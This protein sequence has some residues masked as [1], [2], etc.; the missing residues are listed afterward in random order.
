MFERK[1][2]LWVLSKKVKGQVGIPQCL[3]YDKTRKG[4]PLCSWTPLTSLPYA[5]ASCLTT[6]EETSEET[7]WKTAARLETTQ[8]K[9]GTELPMRGNVKERDDEPLQIPA[10]GCLQ[11]HKWRPYILWPISSAKIF[12]SEKDCDGFFDVDARALENAIC[13]FAT[14]KHV[15]YRLQ[16]C[17]HPR[18]TKPLHRNQTRKLSVYT[19]HNIRGIWFLFQCQRRQREQRFR[20]ISENGSDDGQTWAFHRNAETSMN[21]VALRCGKL[22]VRKARIKYQPRLTWTQMSGVPFYC[23]PSDSCIRG[24]WCH[25]PIVS[26]FQVKWRNF[27][28]CFPAMRQ[29]GLSSNAKRE[30]M[31]LEMWRATPATGHSPEPTS[32]DQ[33]IQ[34]EDLKWKNYCDCGKWACGENHTSKHTSEQGEHRK[35]IANYPGPAF[36]QQL[37]LEQNE[38]RRE[39]RTS[40]FRASENFEDEE[41]LMKWFWAMRNSKSS[42]NLKKESNV[43][44]QSLAFEQRELHTIGG[45]YP[46]AFTQWN[47]AHRSNITSC[48]RAMQNFE[49]G[50]T[51][52][53]AVKL[54]TS[55]CPQTTFKFL[56]WYGGRHSAAAASWQKGTQSL[57]TQRACRES[58]AALSVAFSC[59][60]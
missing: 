9:D 28:G 52:P 34:I 13:N 3:A 25:L 10:N 31:F 14:E 7:A 45:T 18:W 43:Q 16:R 49:R 22:S 41:Q 27:V 35:T 47:H 8:P 59:H 15:P 1:L 48:F 26:C 5:D 19:C 33:S 24:L 50:A 6:C 11:T 44:Q 58:L 37:S 4:I 17:D 46:A 29:S 42:R 56:I 20:Y 54:N 23:N 32:E 21:I 38:L 12:K 2:T 40:C 60:R 53:I 30:H 55:D 51:H 36:E 39:Q 57:C